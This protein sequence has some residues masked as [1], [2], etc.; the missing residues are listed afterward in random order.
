MIFGFNANSSGSLTCFPQ[1]VSIQLQKTDREPKDN[2]GNIAVSR[3]TLL[4][5]SIVIIDNCLQLS[6]TKTMTF[7]LNT[8]RKLKSKKV[9]LNLQSLL[10]GPF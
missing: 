1:S 4:H 5:K 7:A 2:D 6:M 9:F 8:V 10:D 3:L